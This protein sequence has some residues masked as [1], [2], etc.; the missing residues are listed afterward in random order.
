M[1]F[2]YKPPANLP[3]D[4]KEALQ[5]LFKELQ[6]MSRQLQVGEDYA[7]VRQISVAPDKVWDNMEVEVDATLGATVDFGAGGAGRY[8]RRSGAWVKA[9]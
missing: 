7:E 1:P 9:F 2:N 5:V 6:R 8:V 3:D 4:P